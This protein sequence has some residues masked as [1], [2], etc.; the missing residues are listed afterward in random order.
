MRELWHVVQYFLAASLSLP[1]HLGPLWFR[2]FGV[3]EVWGLGCVGFGGFRG[4]GFRV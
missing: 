3:L 4:L 2:G 1:L